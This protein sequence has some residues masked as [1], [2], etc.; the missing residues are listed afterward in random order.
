[1]LRLFVAIY[2][3]PSVAVALLHA[4]DEV[5]LDPA[6]LRTTAPEQVHLTLQFIGDTDLRELPGVAESIRRSM[7]GVRPPRL[8]FKTLITL[9]KGRHPRLIAA[10]LTQDP[11]LLE[12]HRRLASRLARKPKAKD[13]F[14]PH[15]TLARLRAG[16]QPLE[17]PLAGIPAASVA[18]VLLVQSVLHPRRAEH[19]ALERFALEPQG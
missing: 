5:G 10:E 1:M 6:V 9:P 8:E 17:L 14:L 2:P 11:S 13:R 18:E 16:G 15:M 12:L 7:S 19:R 3:P 4:L